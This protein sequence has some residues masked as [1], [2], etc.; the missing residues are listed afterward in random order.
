MARSVHRPPG[1]TDDI[2]DESYK[3]PS[4]V[5]AAAGEGSISHFVLGGVG[6]IIGFLIT[7]VA[8]KPVGNFIANT[9][10]SALKMVEGAAAKGQTHWWGET[11]LGLFGHGEGTFTGLVKA[12]KNNIPGWRRELAAV[13]LKKM[14]TG[15][16]YNVSDGFRKWPGIKQLLSLFGNTEQALK[17]VN[18]SIIG[19]GIMGAF[20]FFIAPIAFWITGVKHANEGKHQFERAKDEIHTLRGQYNE[21]RKKYIEAKTEAEE[22]RVRARNIEVKT[23]DL[24]Q[25]GPM[26]KRRDDRQPGTVVSSAAHETVLSAS[27]SNSITTS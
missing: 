18:T 5:V 6:L 4:R 23:N 9:R 11:L 7:Y 14:E 17:R 15:W 2:T 13:E 12:N 22:H 1:V 26:P 8:H 20:G 10:A 27:K 3:G 25:T 21:L 16:L 19:G 24:T